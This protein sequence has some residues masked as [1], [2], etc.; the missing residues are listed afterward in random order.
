MKEICPHENIENLKEYMNKL[1]KL[2]YTNFQWSDFSIAISHPKIREQ[3]QGLSVEER[4]KKRETLQQE[5]PYW[6]F[7]ETFDREQYI[8]RTGETFEECARKIYETVLQMENCPSHGWEYYSNGEKK[9]KEC[10]F[11][12]LCTLEE[13]MK[14]RSKGRIELHKEYTLHFDQET[15]V[16]EC[17]SHQYYYLHYSAIEKKCYQ[18]T[19]CREFIIPTDEDEEDFMT[20]EEDFKNMYGMYDDMEMRKDVLESFLQRE[21]ERFILHAKYVEKI[22]HTEKIEVWVRDQINIFF[23]ALTIVV[24]L[25]TNQT[26]I[27]G[28]DIQQLQFQSDETYTYRICF[29][30]EEVQEEKEVFSL[31]RKK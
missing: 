30:Q 8:R 1:A 11:K 2:G 4:I 13:M 25:E 12:Q 14:H 15:P 26:R 28:I 31:W 9:C 21:I 22:E 29:H 17:G 18:C 19:S 6:F 10:G 24:R 7:M 16:C 5:Y 20:V 27:T 3:L 23:Q